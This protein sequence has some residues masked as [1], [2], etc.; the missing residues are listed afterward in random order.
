MIGLVIDDVLLRAT[1]LAQK[2]QGVN[3]R[4]RDASV[5]AVPIFAVLSPVV[6][7]F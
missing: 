7:Q 5:V 1:L 6:V 3:G 4:R 2:E